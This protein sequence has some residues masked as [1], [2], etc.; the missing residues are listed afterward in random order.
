MTTPFGHRSSGEPAAESRGMVRYVVPEQCIFCGTAGQVA[1]T[2]RTHG[3]AVAICWHCVAC[4]RDWPVK[5]TEQLDERHS[6][7]RDRRRYS[8]A[9]RRNRTR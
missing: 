3:G 8:R 7:R 5:P 9:D 4:G 1:L 6:G 2:A